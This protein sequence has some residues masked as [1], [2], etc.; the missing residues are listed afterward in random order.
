LREIEL[1]PVRRL[2][3][4]GGCWRHLAQDAGE[5]RSR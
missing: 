3:L 4:A 5:T 1:K 2:T